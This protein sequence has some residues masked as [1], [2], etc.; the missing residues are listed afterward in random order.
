MKPLNVA[1]VHAEL[2]YPTEELVTRQTNNKVPIGLLTPPTLSAG[3]M[4]L[5]VA[6]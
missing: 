3:R 5:S 2:F 1:Q 6:S 4:P